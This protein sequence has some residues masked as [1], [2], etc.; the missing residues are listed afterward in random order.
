MKNISVIIKSGLTPARDRIKIFFIVA[1]STLFLIKTFEYTSKKVNEQTLMLSLLAILMVEN[2]LTCGVY[3]SLK[4]TISGIKFTHKIFISSALKFFI[5]FLLIKM[6]FI[7]FVIFFAGLL[8]IVVEAAGKLSLPAAASIAFLWLVWLAIPA[9]YFVLSL[10][11]PVVLFSQDTEI[12]QSIKMGIIFTR[13]FLNE[14]I[15]IAFFYFFSIGLLVYLPEKLYN[16]EST[17]WTI[18][19]SITASIF[20]VGFISSLFLFYEKERNHERNV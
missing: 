9:Y 20:E 18:Y 10:F 16:F 12:F 14:I 2:F 17:A 11:A 7:I 1:C 4:K 13:K 8:L 5:R 3:G 15:V 19:K 6:L